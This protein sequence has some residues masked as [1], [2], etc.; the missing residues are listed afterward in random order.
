MKFVS[1]LPLQPTYYKLLG[2]L[3]QKQKSFPSMNGNGAPESV[4]FVDV[5]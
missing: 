2:A 3:L 5:R 4:N 1:P